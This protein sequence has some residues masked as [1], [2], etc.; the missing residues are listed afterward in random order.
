MSDKLQFNTPKGRFVS[1][2]LTELVTKDRNG[3]PIDPD[4]QRREF[5]LA[6]PKDD[7][8]LPQLLQD[9]AAYAKSAYASHPVIQ[10]RIDGWFQT[11][12]GFSM[13]IS[14]GDK[15]AVSTGR[16][17]ENTA[18]CLVI[19]FST[20]LSIN[21]CGPDNVQIDPAS[22]KRGWY[23]DVAGTCAVNNLTDH[24]AGIYMNPNWVRLREYGQE[25]VGGVD[26]ATAFGGTTHAAL[27]PA[28]AGN[29][30]GMPGGGMPGAQQPAPMPGMPQANPTQP[31]ATPPATPQQ[32]APMPGAPAGMPQTGAAPVPGGQTASPG[33]APQ[34]GYPPHPG[35]MMPGTPQS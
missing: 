11:M 30:Q 15:P 14:D 31:A 1:G 33:E 3:R 27:G 9:I 12:T 13:K 17:N 7:P 32:G 28:P 23:I 35:V 20:A 21:V 22:I 34:T 10:Q 29:V 18:G 24:N 26:A 16:V 4:K 5:G 2:S 8:A 25:I 19:W 6:I